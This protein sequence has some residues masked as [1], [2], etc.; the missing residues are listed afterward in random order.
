MKI[1]NG[2][3]WDIRNLKSILVKICDIEMV[4]AK[5]RKRLRVYFDCGKKTDN[6]YDDHTTGR[7]YIDSCEVFIFLPRE[8]I[9]KPS[10]ALVLAHEVAHNHG[11]RHRSMNNPGYNYKGNWKEIYAWVRDMPLERKKVR[12]KLTELAIARIKLGKT[13]ALLKKWST[14]KKLA[15]TKAQTYKSRCAY[16]QKRIDKP[17]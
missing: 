6:S 4:D 5:Y 1:S 2:T 13:Q 17:S 9:Y 8:E 3:H 14:K 11:V 12:A 15:T 16:Y 10:L 7:A